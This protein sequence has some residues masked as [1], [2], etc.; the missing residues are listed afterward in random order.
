MVSKP[1]L[2][3]KNPEKI[4]FAQIK[5][6]QNN[7]QK[8]KFKIQS[9]WKNNLS[10]KE[11]VNASFDFLSEI[12]MESS[13]PTFTVDLRLSETQGRYDILKSQ[14][15]SIWQPPRK[16]RLE[17]KSWVRNERQILDG[18][19]TGS[20][21]VF[22]RTVVQVGWKESIRI[23]CQFCYLHIARYVWRQSYLL[24]RLINSI[25]SMYFN[26]LI[27]RIAIITGFAR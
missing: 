24:A 21:K 12:D 4:S 3:Q 16:F 10:K 7:D 18:A 17:K 2:N 22:I 20:R 1:V 11:K 23:S 15:N 14:L 19:V 5:T 13:R 25:Q 26:L 6:K 27:H 9:R 8:S